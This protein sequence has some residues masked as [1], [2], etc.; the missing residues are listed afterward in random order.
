MIKPIFLGPP[1]IVHSQKSELSKLCIQRLLTIVCC[2]H[3][4]SIII[5]ATAL[6]IYSKLMKHKRYRFLSSST[7]GQHSHQSSAR[8]WFWKLSEVPD[9]LITCVMMWRL[10]LIIQLLFSI[11][12]AWWRAHFI[13]QALKLLG[14]H[15]L[16]ESICWTLERHY[17]S[18]KQNH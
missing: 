8:I 12:P 18:R 14:W 1:C 16:P 6:K 17:L 2:K 13:C 15:L 9:H 10:R 7:P 11:K 3:N 4:L 5:Y